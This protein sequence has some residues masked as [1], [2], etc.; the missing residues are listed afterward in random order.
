ML[1]MKILVAPWGQFWKVS[2][3]MLAGTKSQKE[4]GTGIAKRFWDWTEAQALPYL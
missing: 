2:D 3:D 1:T 4:G